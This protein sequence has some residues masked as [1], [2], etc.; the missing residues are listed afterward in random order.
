MSETKL[1]R[2]NDE[3]WEPVTGWHAVKLWGMIFAFTVIMCGVVYKLG[4]FFFGW[5]F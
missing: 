4:E 2:S 5:M 1:S 3:G